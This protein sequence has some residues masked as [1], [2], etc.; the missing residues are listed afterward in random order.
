MRLR[1]GMAWLA[2]VFWAAF[3]IC[4][5]GKGT[6]AEGGFYNTTDWRSPLLLAAAP[7]PLDAQMLGEK[8]VP[9][10]SNQLNLL[11]RTSGLKID[12][13]G[14]SLKL[15]QNLE[16]NISF[17]YNRN[18]PTVAP[19][20]PSSS[21]PAFN[22]SVD[23]RLLPNLKVGLTGY[24]YYPNADQS[25]SLSQPFG[26]RVMGL[27]PGIRYDLG[28]WSLVFKSQLETGGARDRGD[29]LQNWLRVWYAF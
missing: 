22:Y 8:P 12:G 27:G 15:P 6:A 3:I 13:A 16:F 10:T 23:Y 19:M 29:D 18:A 24:L 5:P 7:A 11:E 21:L 28:H 2:A 17:L 1:W 9:S 20:R 4:L 14:T 25:F 26:E